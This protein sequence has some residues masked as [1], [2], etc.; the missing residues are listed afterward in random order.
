MVAN[1][2][3]N[4]RCISYSGS[5]TGSFGDISITFTNTLSTFSFPFLVSQPGPYPSAPHPTL[6]HGASHLALF[7]EA[8]HSSY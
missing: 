3:T 6:C 2:L 1:N 4:S 7:Q 8:P 5:Q